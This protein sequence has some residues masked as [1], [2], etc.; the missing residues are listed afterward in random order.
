MIKGVIFDMDGVLV[1]NDE[2]HQRAFEIWC[3]RNDMSLPDDFLTKFYGMGNDDI[4]P[5]IFGHPLPKEDIARYATEKEAIYREIYAP[6][7]TPTAGLLTVLDELKARGIK[8]AVGSSGSIENIMMVLEGCGIKDYFSAISHSGLVERA[9]PAPDVFLLAAKLLELEPSECTVIED[10]FAGIRAA[11]AA[12]MRLG[13]LATSFAR[14]KHT[15]YDFIADDF[16]DISI[17]E[18]VNTASL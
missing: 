5:G 11:R 17:D 14:E 2:Y 10:A 9:K 16:R 18:I 3:E 8:M 13:V 6:D 7:V 4:F 1:I 15:D 12:G